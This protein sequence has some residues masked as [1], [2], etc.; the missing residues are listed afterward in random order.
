MDL[1]FLIESVLQQVEE[2]DEISKQLEKELNN[3]KSQYEKDIILFSKLKEIQKDDATRIQDC[4]DLAEYRKFPSQFFIDKGIFYY[5][6]ISFVRENKFLLKSSLTQVMNSPFDGRY[7]LPIC[8]PN[9]KVFTYM[10]Y[11]HV[12]GEEKYKVPMLPWISQGSLMGNLESLSK[13]PDSPIVKICEGMMD[14]YRIE[15]EEKIPAVANLG[16]KL[17][18]AK[19]QGL[20]YINKILGKTLI[21]VPDTGASG[22]KEEL[23]SCEYFSKIDSYPF[24]GDI[25]EYYALRR[26]GITSKKELELYLKE[27]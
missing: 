3:V 4:K 22:T 10:G 18:K 16:S 25:D 27:K 26:M 14:A 13:Y 11:T 5:E 2:V 8:L 21:Y 15:C 12:K 6:N 19:K 9:G 23:L 24:G 20:H 1:E 17:T 7:L